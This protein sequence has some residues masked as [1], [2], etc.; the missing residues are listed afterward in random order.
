MARSASIVPM[1][2]LRRTATSTNGVPPAFQHL[3]G[4]ISDL[5]AANRRLRADNTELA[6]RVNTYAQVIRELSSELDTLRAQTALQDNVRL[7]YARPGTP[8]K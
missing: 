6:E 8:P 2:S 4:K 3:S 1:P 7:L 5:V